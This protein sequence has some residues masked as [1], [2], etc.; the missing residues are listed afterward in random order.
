VDDPLI[1]GALLAGAA[2]AFFVDQV[3]KALA[4]RLLATGPCQLLGRWAG[5]RWVLNPR[6]GVLAMPLRWAIIAWIAAIACGAALVVM[7]ASASLGIGVGLGLALGG[8]TSNLTDRVLR[9]AVADF[10]AVWRWPA[11]NLADA[12]MVAGTMLVAGGFL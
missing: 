11:F 12:A 1:T 5:F 7:Q 9:G 2:A 10:I 6:A 3:S 4:A 8:A